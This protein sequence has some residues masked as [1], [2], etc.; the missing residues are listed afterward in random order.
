MYIEKDASD[1]AIPFRTTRQSHPIPAGVGGG[2]APTVY[3]AI[4]RLVR[5]R[6]IIG[7]ESLSVNAIYAL[8]AL[9]VVVGS[10]YRE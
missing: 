2:R 4:Y 7:S 10:P 5:N 8:P 6:N 9:V 3:R 1:Q